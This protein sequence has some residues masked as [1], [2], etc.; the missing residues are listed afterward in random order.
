MENQNRL[1]EFLNKLVIFIDLVRSRNL[2][3]CSE[4]WNAI[5]IEYGM[6]AKMAPT[7]PT[8]T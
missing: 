5:N 4:F 8:L 6:T 1:C 7:C 2:F 3:K